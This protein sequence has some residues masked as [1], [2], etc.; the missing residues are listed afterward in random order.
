MSNSIWEKEGT[1]AH[2]FWN[3]GKL[4]D[5]PVYDMHGHM[6]H[7]NSIY[8][9]HSSPAE[10]AAHI[11][12]AGVKRLVYCSHPALWGM[13]RNVEMIKECASEPDVLRMYMAINPN[14][15][16]EIREDLANYDKFTPWVFGLKL[17][18]DYHKVSAT[19]AKY[20]YALDFANERELPV[21]IHTWGG[22]RFDGGAVMLELVQKY[23]RI[24]FLLGHS[25]FGEWEYARRC[26]QESAGNVY[27]ELTSI[28]GN[29]GDLERLT[30]LVG[31]EKLIFGTD[32]PWFDEYQ[33]IGG[34]LAADITEG[35]KRNIFYRNVERIFGKDW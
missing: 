22:S 20:Q 32:M 1:L 14:Y 24:K 16:E 7:L 13:C 27:L 31:S 18:P 17:L 2:G 34:V 5:C 6:N 19:D 4:T 30:A 35:D 12:R 10:V 33:A 8:F 29:M 28:P 21:L 26:V 3:N 15:P 9:P 11:R 23:S 25:I